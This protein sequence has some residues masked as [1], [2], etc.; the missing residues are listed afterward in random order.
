M[1]KIQLTGELKGFLN[2]KE[3][4][5]CPITFSVADIK[6]V[7]KKKGA[8]SKSITLIG[9]K[10]NN[11]L[12]GNIFDV[13][14][15]Q[16]TFNINKVVECNIL[17]N[18]IPILEN[19]IFQLV[20]INKITNDKSEDEITYT[21]LVKDNIGDF[22][23]QINNKELTD[24]TGFEYMRHTYTADKVIES[25]NNTIVDGY[26]Y[27][28]PY[29]P[30]GNTQ[31]DREDT[32]LDLTEFSPGIYTKIYF[33]KIF[34]Q[35]GYSYQWDGMD[36]EHTNF[37]KLIIPFNGEKPVVNAVEVIDYTAEVQNTSSQDIRTRTQNINPVGVGSYRYEIIQSTYDRVNMTNLISDPSNRWNT[38][39]SRYN[40]P[41]LP[42]NQN[43]IQIE[44][45]VDWELITN[46]FGTAYLKNYNT[47]SSFKF[48][49]FPTIKMRRFGTAQ[50]LAST[51]I[52]DTDGNFF[53][54]NDGMYISNG[55]SILK[56][57]TSTFTQLAQG[58]DPTFDI[59]VACNVNTSSGW[60]FKATNNIAGT[61]RNSTSFGLRITNI[62]VKIKTMVEGTY[63]YNIPVDMK[64]YV[65]QK[66][67]QSDFIKSILTMYNLYVDVD[68]DN[69]KQLNLISRD[70]YYDSGDI[71]DWTKKLVKNKPQEVRFIPEVASKSII[72]TYK[73]D[74]DISNKI[75]K[76]ASG[77][78][79]G[80]QKF[81]FDNEFVR[82][83]K[84]QE[85]T[86]SPT[87]IF[88]TSFGAICPMW[89]GGSPKC[90][91]RILYDGGE[92]NCNTYNIV[93]YRLN[94]GTTN[95]VSTNKYPHIS[96]WNKPTNPTFDLNFG[97]CD[98][99]FRS[100]DFGSLT[101]NN[102]FNLHWRRTF[103]QI[104]TGKIMTCEF[105][106]N[107]TDIS[108]LKL[109]DKI[110]IDNSWWNINKVQDYDGNSNKSTKVE[111]ISI[112]DNLL[113]PFK[114]RRIKV[115]KDLSSDLIATPVRTISKERDKFLTVNLSPYDIEVRGKYNYILNDVTNATIIG[116]GNLISANSQVY[117]NDNVI[118]AE[119]T[120][121]GNNNIIEEDAVG[122]VVNGNGVVV[123]TPSEG[124]FVDLNSDQTITGNKT[125]N[126]VPLIKKT[127]SYSYPS[128]SGGLFTIGGNGGYD[129]FDFYSIDGNDSDGFGTTQIYS[130]P[131]EGNYFR[132][133]SLDNQ[134]SSILRVNYGDTYLRHIFGGQQTSLY[135][136]GITDKIIIEGTQN[137]F[138]NLG[139]SL[140]TGSKTF[141]FPN[142][143]G[144]IALTSDIVGGTPNI[145]VTRLQA[146]TLESTNG[147]VVGVSYTIT[148]ADVGLYGGTEVT[149]LAIEPNKLSLQG[150]GKFYCPK[151]D[152]S[153]L[154]NGY[155]MW[156]KYMDGT[157][158]TITGT[159]TNNETVT[160]NNGA[161]AKFLTIGFL[162][163]ISGDWSGAT[164][165]TGGT[166][167]ATCTVS[168]FVSPSYSIG[169]I[170]HWGGKSWTNVNGNVGNS[171]DDYTMNSEWSEISFNDVDYNVFVDEIHYDFGNDMIIYRKDSYGNELESILIIS[172]GVRYI[173]NFKWGCF[174]NDEN[175]YYGIGNNKILN[176][177]INCINTL[178]N[179][180][181][182]TLSSNSYIQN[183]TLS[184]NSR[185]Y[186]NTLSS[187]SYIQ[188]NTLSSSRISNNTL[189]SSSRIQSNT[190]SG[191][192]DIQNNTLNNSI[193]RF[194]NI[195]T[196]IQNCQANTFNTSGS[197][198]TLSGS[199]IIGSLYSKNLFS[200]MDGGN[201]LSYVNNSNNQII[202]NVNA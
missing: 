27:I 36:D 197:T 174:F 148:D 86:F 13:N 141:E 172:S 94:S 111:L 107:E 88:N 72:L 170:V 11:K 128:T 114:T 16:G 64:R 186:N 9:D 193:F 125:F 173:K 85:I 59:E 39:A 55:T 93:N 104:N 23:T 142:A 139:T 15:S 42:S 175:F 116:D 194:L 165:I 188:D 178:G 77:E 33:D 134:Q 121:T 162:E 102:L 61:N 122:S 57:G 49:V 135:V 73:E 105:L 109:N 1:T 199:T 161:I 187:N 191:G 117:G 100:D 156:T 151:Y 166:S 46:S 153:V 82:E 120:V 115:I 12:L 150:S 169:D 18:E 130:N 138:A 92:Y 10:N 123:V 70:K 189:S 68:K 54:F 167:G 65:P 32:S 196:N 80:Q 112:D 198:I 202:T 200:R 69:P 159:F 184:S 25:F 17:Q 52:L 44:Y 22:F 160:A 41:N 20:S 190:L 158:V 28:M 192:Y 152:L 164:S 126:E 132:H 131:E 78:I 127:A 98:Y 45:E 43:S 154:N 75:Y 71:K 79:Y 147:F 99:Y 90:N 74:S 155:G 185:I 51:N 84:K 182:N 38:L 140:I 179:I 106:L 87:P 24:L 201:R 2:L 168:G 48:N 67:K 195:S 47:S 37:S 6:D 7:T 108:N 113:I 4:T 163:W 180:L 96:H 91:L 101:N 62:R 110:R 144:T 176:G 81:T 35:A 53:K 124:T 143:S 133:T 19:G 40:P 118:S 56:S 103:N 63:G 14:V 97:V 177:H 26:K 83:E 3:D 58:I 66:V 60:M 5:A 30:E 50:Y 146:E 171:T 95:Q 8:F 157:F 137:K 21:C 136:N 119:S 31:A 29:T 76:E 89:L 149:L 181:N 145:R 129:R 183:N 34:Q